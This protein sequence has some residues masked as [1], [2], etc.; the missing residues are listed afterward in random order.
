MFNIKGSDHVTKNYAV[1]KKKHT[2]VWVVFL[3]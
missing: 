1:L 3:V 2:Y